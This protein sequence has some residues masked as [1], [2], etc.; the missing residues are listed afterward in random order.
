MPVTVN[1][2]RK[3]LCHRGSG[4][5]SRATLPD[6]CK[7]PG[8]GIP[9]PYPNIAFSRDLAMG[10]RSITADGGHMCAKYGSKFAKSIGDAPGSLGGVKSGTVLHKATWITYSFD[11]KLEGKGACRLTDKMFHNN[12]NTVNAAGLN[13]ALISEI[14][15]QLLCA[16]DREVNAKYKTAAAK[17]KVRCTELGNQKQDC[18]D[19]KLKKHRAKGKRIEGERGYNKTTGKWDGSRMTRLERFQDLASRRKSGTYWRSISKPKA[20][21]MRTRIPRGGRGSMGAEMAGEGLLLILADYMEK[22]AARMV[23]ER[24]AALAN[25]AFPDGAIRTANGQLENILEFKFQCPPGHGTGR[26]GLSKGGTPQGF[27]KGQK[28]KYSKL[29]EAMSANTPGSVADGA[30]VELVTN[31]KC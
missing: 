26:A 22:R 24:G 10:T 1:I 17:S 16:C 30:T 19:K 11:V 8:N 5:I 3:S 25:T 6:V 27:S 9:L 12:S 13:Q 21:S 14:R 29:M 20:P 7:T 28:E 4:G 18:L 2:N 15:D 31:E 23:A